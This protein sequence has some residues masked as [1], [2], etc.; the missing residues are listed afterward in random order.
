MVPVDINAVARDAIQ[1]AQLGDPSPIALHASFFEALPPVEG[2]P[3]Q[4][5]QALCNLLVSARESLDGVDGGAIEIETEPDGD[6]VAVR[7]LD[8]GP[9]MPVD[10]LEQIF[11]PFP[12]ATEKW[13]DA[14]D[15]K[16]PRDPFGLSDAYEIVRAHSGTLVVRSRPGQGT[17]FIALIPTRRS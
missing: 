2:S 10:R 17:C 11:D 6:L 9:G 15:G 16:Q 7:I 14:P 1:L 5:T 13:C 8:N 12:S 3:E 4:L